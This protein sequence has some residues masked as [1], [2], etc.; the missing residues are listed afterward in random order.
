MAGRVSPHVASVPDSL[1]FRRLATF[2]AARFCHPQGRVPRRLSAEEMRHRYVHDG[3][4]LRSGGAVSG[5][6]MPRRAGQ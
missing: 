1:G 2:H 5:D 4:A 3:F 6:A